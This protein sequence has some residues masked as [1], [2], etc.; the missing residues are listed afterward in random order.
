MS[1]LKRSFVLLIGSLLM[2]GAAWAQVNRGSITGIVT[3]PSGAVVANVAITVTNPATGVTNN[4]TTNSSGVYT[5]PLLGAAT[6]RLDAQATGFKQYEQTNT[7]VQVGQPVRLDF[8]L[9]LGSEPQSVQVSAQAPLLQR[10]SSDTGTSVT[11]QQVEVLPLT[12]FDTQRPPA[13]FIQLAPGTTGHGNSDGGPGAN[14]TMTTSVSGSM[15]S[16]TTMLLDGADVTSVGAFEGD[17][18]ALQLP[19]DAV[20]E[21]KL[22]STNGSAEYGRSGGGTASFQVKS[23]TNQ[24]HGTAYEF[25]RNDALNANNFFQNS[26]P[27]GCDASGHQS[28]NPIKACRSPYK[29]NEFGV[30][31]GGPIKKDKA[32]IF[33]YYDGFRLTQGVS[34]GLATIPT[35]QM[36]QGDFTNYGTTDTNGV[37]TM[38][39]LYDPTTHTTCGPLIC[40]NKISPSNFDPVSAKV[41]P[42]MPTPSNPDPRAVFNNYTSTVA[43]PFSVNEWG[44]KDDYIINEKNRL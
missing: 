27:P 36:K 38:T 24:I 1:H 37:F 40:G 15:V 41:I 10:E 12:T 44:L 7:L 32:F 9:T 6:Y 17:L 4:V 23:G 26:S 14:R 5:V 19:P 11:S 3:D 42:L 8:A 13:T 22:E 30:T 25:L 16:S 18:R 21:F 2:A 31:A 28:S 33:G 43:N 34:S 39:P 35:E 20:Q 29:Q